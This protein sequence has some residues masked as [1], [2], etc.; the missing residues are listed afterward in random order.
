MSDNLT[1]APRRER[2]SEDPCVTAHRVVHD[3]RRDGIGVHVPDS[4]MPR[5]AQQAALL[6]EALGVRASVPDEE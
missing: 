3:L 1:P 6:P 2:S 4:R 5:A